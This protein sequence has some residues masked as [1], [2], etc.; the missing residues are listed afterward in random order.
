MDFF[1]ALK[2]SPDAQARLQSILSPSPTPPRPTLPVVSPLQQ[3]IGI[4][5]STLGTSAA[6]LQSLYP[7]IGST[8]RWY[9]GIKSLIGHLP[10]FPLSAFET[11]THAAPV[12]DHDVK[13]AAFLDEFIIKHPW[14]IHM[15][16]S[17]PSDAHYAALL[18]QF[19]APES[20]S[21]P[22]LPA[23]D[24]SRAIF[25]IAFF[26]RARKYY[27]NHGKVSL[28]SLLTDNMSLLK[29]RI[30]QLKY[31]Q[32][33]FDHPDS[34]YHIGWIYYAN[35][36]H[37]SLNKHLLIEHVQTFRQSRLSSPTPETEIKSRCK[38]IS[39][40]MTFLHDYESIWSDPS[41]AFKALKASFADNFA[42]SN[43]KSYVDSIA[44]NCSSH[45][46]GTYSTDSSFGG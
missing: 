23:P 14:A 26:Q 22:E 15:T 31:P 46:D 1:N 40:Y 37:L 21:K 12:V 7:D 13:A 29:A 2:D 42:Y 39:D 44:S 30:D 5:A 36:Q 32:Y 4:I 11:W 9:D 45:H 18:L 16:G 8:H 10:A 33:Q 3:N 28:E 38:Y 43:V 41:S 24:T 20:A 34:R 19:Q 27:R 6:A 35:F 17:V 25:V